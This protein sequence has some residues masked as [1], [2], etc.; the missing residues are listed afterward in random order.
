MYLNKRG[1]VV[2]VGLY[3]VADK[4]AFVGSM[5]SRSECFLGFA[6][7]HEPCFVTPA[8]HS[9][10]LTHTNVSRLLAPIHHLLAIKGVDHYG[11]LIGLAG[12]QLSLCDPHA[13]TYLSKFGTTF[14]IKDLCNTYI[15]SSCMLLYHSCTLF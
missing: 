9:F 3:R 8:I 5:S 12:Q 15:T 13:Y 4:L 14:W 11:L 6:Y 10:S 7:A 1:V 2:L